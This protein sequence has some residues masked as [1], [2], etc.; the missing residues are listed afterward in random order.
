MILKE[1]DFDYLTYIE[2]GNSINLKDLEIAKIQSMTMLNEYHKRKKVLNRL[3]EIGL[4]RDIKRE[5]DFAYKF[6]TTNVCYQI[7]RKLS[8]ELPGFINPLIDDQCKPKDMYVKLLN[9]LLRIDNDKV[10]IRDIIEYKGKLVIVYSDKLIYSEGDIFEDINLYNWSLGYLKALNSV[11]QTLR[12]NQ[13]FNIK[14]RHISYPNGAKIYLSFE[15]GLFPSSYEEYF[16]I[17][18]VSDKMPI[19]M[20]QANLLGYTREIKDFSC[21]SRSKEIKQREELRR[22]RIK[23]KYKFDK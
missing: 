7:Y 16:T 8:E 14:E 4:L 17:L 5:N 15:N 19:K 20:A 10:F 11:F 21:L 2:Y 23:E 3:P 9:N 1:K 13:S 6:W 12:V 22:E 18:I